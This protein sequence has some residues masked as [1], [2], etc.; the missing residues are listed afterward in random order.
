MRVCVRERENGQRYANR[1]VIIVLLTVGLR[2]NRPLRSRASNFT[3][4]IPGW[5]PVQHPA[6]RIFEALVITVSRPKPFTR[7][8]C[9][10]YTDPNSDFL[11]F[12]SSLPLLPTDFPFYLLFFCFLFSLRG[13]R[14]LL[15]NRAGE[16][17]NGAFTRVNALTRVM[18]RPRE[19][20]RLE[21]IRGKLRMRV[22]I[23]FPA[24]ALQPEA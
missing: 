8:S 16:R 14:V 11:N 17:K 18:C 7:L 4:A 20:P 5:P 13:R 19:C 24:G 22:C 12:Y 15:L 9:K 10:M 1:E 21:E 6:N 23:H 2:L 3:L